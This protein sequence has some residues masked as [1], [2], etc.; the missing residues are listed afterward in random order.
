MKEKEALILQLY[1]ATTI[2]EEKYG[3]ATSMKIV[4]LQGIALEL[5]KKLQ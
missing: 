4:R 5:N 3:G 2:L 1:N